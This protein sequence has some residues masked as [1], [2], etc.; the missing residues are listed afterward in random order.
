MVS[1]RKRQLQR[2]KFLIPIALILDGSM[3]IAVPTHA[4]VPQDHLILVEVE[5]DTDEGY[6]PPTF[7]IRGEQSPQQIPAS[8]VPMDWLE[9][10]GDKDSDHPEV[11]LHQPTAP[12]TPV[13]LRQQE[14]PT[15]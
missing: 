9:P 8:P 12:A 15:D 5:Q 14:V 10:D 6:N 11:N 3:A 13:P 2:L 4:A 1:L 7:V